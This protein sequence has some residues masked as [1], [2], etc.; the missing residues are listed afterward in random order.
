MRKI[1]AIILSFSM[2]F[3]LV[4][5]K[6]KCEHTYSSA[7]TKEANCVEEGLITYSCSKCGDS[8]TETIP[9]TD[10]HTYTS[11]IIKKATVSETGI[12]K[13]TCTR[14]GHSYTEEIAKKIGHWE[15]SES[16]G[17]VDG[18]FSASCAKADLAGNQVETGY[19][20]QIAIYPSGDLVS[21]IFL[22]DGSLISFSDIFILG[23]EVE[24]AKGNE[25]EVSL[26]FYDGD[27]DNTVLVSS[28]PTFRRLIEDN[29]TLH[30][31]LKTMPKKN[32]YWYFNTT[33][34]NLGLSSELE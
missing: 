15:K 25:Y 3:S 7:I 13:Y 5:C 20:C 1:A 14:C 18:T 6:K 2:I 10:E 28:D 9:K 29:E 34:D 16:G 8:Y 26:S 30:L 23:M 31:V 17:Y 21:I 4:S 12:K 24:D 19:F 32:E 11:E 22:K 27:P 33:I